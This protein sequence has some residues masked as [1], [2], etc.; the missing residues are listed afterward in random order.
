MIDVDDI[1]LSECLL[2][3]LS[4]APTPPLMI[5]TVRGRLHVYCVEPSPSRPIDLEVRYQGRRCL[6]QLL[7]AGCVAAAPPTPGY[8]WINQDAEPFYGTVGA[9]WNRIAKTLGL[10]YKRATPYSFL[11]RERSRGPTTEQIREA[12]KW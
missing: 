9:V 4:A 1:G 10:P 5:S 12:I 6:V 7:S 8:A 3:Y 11:R 2:G